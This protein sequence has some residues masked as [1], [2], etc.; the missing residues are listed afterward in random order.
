[1]SG[2][3]NISS[4]SMFGK[5]HTQALAL[6]SFTGWFCVGGVILA[7][8]EGIGIALTRAQSKQY[9]PGE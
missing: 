5:T 2:C 8:I 1:M 4:M 6:H 3:G 9:K 7:L